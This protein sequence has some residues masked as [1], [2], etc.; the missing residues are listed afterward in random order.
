MNHNEFKSRGKLLLGACGAIS[1]VHLCSWI[2][3]L[4]MSFC[5]N[6]QV[7]LTKQASKM[8]N[9]WVVSQFTQNPTYTD[10]FEFGKPALHASLPAES[11]LFLIMPSTANTMGK[12]ANGIC[13]DLLTAAVMNARCPVVFVPFMNMEMW[14]KKAVQ[15]NV[16]KLKEEGYHVFYEL[17][18]NYKISDGAQVMSVGMDLDKLVIKLKRLII[19]NDPTH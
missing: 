18:Q 13:D 16:R 5:E 14:E 17:K 6:I 11:D 7:I 9:P 4:R 2:T 3:F 8:I 19:Q 12:V 15:R 1:V 10:F